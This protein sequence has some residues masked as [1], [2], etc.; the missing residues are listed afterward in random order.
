VTGYKGIV[1]ADC[2]LIDVDDKV[3]LARALEVARDLQIEFVKRV[4]HTI[5]FLRIRF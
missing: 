4:P 5:H 3:N 2:L 1:S